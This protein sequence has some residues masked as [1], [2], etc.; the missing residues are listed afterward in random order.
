MIPPEFLRERGQITVSCD[1]IDSEIEVKLDRIVT[2]ARG[3][4]P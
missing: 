1:E 4:L 2:V 3:Q